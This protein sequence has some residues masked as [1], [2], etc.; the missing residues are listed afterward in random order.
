M[1]VDCI[2]ARRTREHPQGFMMNACSL[3]EEKGAH[4]GVY[5]PHSKCSTCPG[6]DDGTGHVSRVIDFALARRIAIDWNRDLSCESCG[7]PTLTLDETL[8]ALKAR[9]MRK[10]EDALVRAV[11]VGG[12]PQAQAQALAEAHFGIAES[13]GSTGTVEST[14]STESTEKE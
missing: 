14:E 10:A 2:H 8:E 3:A 5:I 1:S 4:C 9:D 12:M 13:V 6:R 11:E 7:G